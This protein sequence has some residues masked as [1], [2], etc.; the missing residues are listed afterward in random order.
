MLILISSQTDKNGSLSSD[1]HLA[2]YCRAKRQKFV[3]IGIITVLVLLILLI[4]YNKIF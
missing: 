4:L 3:T 2:G 1:S